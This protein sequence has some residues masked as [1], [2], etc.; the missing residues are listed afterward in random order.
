M[1]GGL[2]LVTTGLFGGAIQDRIGYI[3]LGIIVWSA[4][5][6]IVMEG[7]SVFVRNGGYIQS[8]NISI[9]L[10]VGR[11]VF[12]VLIIFSHQLVLYAI[13]ILFGFVALGWNCLLAVPGLVLLLINAYWIVT[14]LGFLCARY[15]DLEPI[16]RNLLQLA[17]LV[18]PV[19]WDAKIMTGHQRLFLIE[20]NPLYHFIALVRM[21]LLDEIPQI[22]SYIV[23]LT[24]TVFGYMIAYVVYR[25]MRRNLALF[26]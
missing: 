23:V 6:A 16:I 18:T 9:D 5:S 4:I 14:T 13:G 21:P 19:F 1:V 10:Y 3:G 20:Y 22:R 26:V 25:Q 24:V 15:R 12:K 17:F 7:C 11:T 2:S 8:T